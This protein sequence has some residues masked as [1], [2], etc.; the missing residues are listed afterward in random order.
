MDQSSEQ[1]SR[2]N[3]G[4]FTW[5][6]QKFPSVLTSYDLLKTIAVLLMVID[7]I[8]IYFYPD[9]SW[10]RVLGRLCV[11]IWFFL[12]GYARTRDI[13]LKVLLGAVLIAVGN[14]AAGEVLLPLS[15]LV[16]LMI[17]RYYVDVW[18]RPARKG[19]EAF[20]GL[21]F[22][23]LIL[24][25]PASIIFEYG[26]LGFLFTVFGALCRYRQDS[27]EKLSDEYTR[28]I[29]FFA[30]A[31]FVVFTVLQAMPMKYLDG[32]QLC[33]LVLG[34][35]AVY[36]VLNR[37]RYSELVNITNALPSFFVRLFQL[38]G[39]YT[40]EIYVLHLLVFKMYGLYADP[41]RFQFMGWSWAS[42]GTVSFLEAI[43][44]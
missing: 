10:F 6:K 12:I 38:T 31:S 35:A 26:T 20:A 9:E 43:M 30:A 29:T 27:G 15:I 17:G 11:P 33:V 18:M 44:K 22:F 2:P 5:K 7:H 36:F 16:T 21:F 4:R 42:E 8:G 13:S 14:M 37:F 41:E 39:R 40:L 34:M 3:F 25:M 23:L 19:G 32:A 1:E 24:Y 28:Q